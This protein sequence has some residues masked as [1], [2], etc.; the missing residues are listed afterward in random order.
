MA[1]KIDRPETNGRIE[2]WANST[3]DQLIY[4]LNDLERRCDEI[5][6]SASALQG[7]IEQIQ[8]KDISGELYQ[9][10]VKLSEDLT[11]LS[12]SVETLSGSIE[13]LSGSIETINGNIETIN[14]NYTALEA[15]VTALEGS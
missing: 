11:T 4:A 9:L 2:Q 1:Y 10:I 13:T 6:T 3:T 14:E 15:R 12:G 8:E 7:N 5:T